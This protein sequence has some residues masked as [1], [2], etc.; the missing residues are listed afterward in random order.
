MLCI[1]QFVFAGNCLEGVLSDFYANI[2]A[3][4]PRGNG[5]TKPIA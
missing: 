3:K 4:G 5:F 1:N 2:A